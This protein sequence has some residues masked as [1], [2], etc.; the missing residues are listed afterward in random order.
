GADSGRGDRPDG[1]VAERG[2]DVLAE[3]LPIVTS[4]A[5]AQV[6]PG[7]PGLRVGGESERRRDWLRGRTPGV[8]QDVGLLECQPSFR[9]GLRR[10]RHGAALGGAGGVPDAVRALVAGLPATGGE[11]ANLAEAAPLPG[12]HGWWSFCCRAPSVP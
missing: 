3:Y 8:A 10:E 2:E 9:I 7:Q 4:G 1:Q 12:G 6:T 5:V 11:L